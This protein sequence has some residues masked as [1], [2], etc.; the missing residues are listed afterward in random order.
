[1]WQGEHAYGM[2][3]LVRCRNLKQLIVM[4]VWR[5]IM[6]HGCMWIPPLHKYIDIVCYEQFYLLNPVRTQWTPEPEPVNL[7][8]RFRFKVRKFLNRTSTVTLWSECKYWVS[9]T[10]IIYLPTWFDSEA[11]AM[12]Y[13]LLQRWILCMINPFERKWWKIWRGKIILRW[14]PCGLRST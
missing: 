5:P 6:K 13:L 2:S 10:S 1:M 4:A 11:V 3:S 9:S 7:H 8:W 14:I 12:I